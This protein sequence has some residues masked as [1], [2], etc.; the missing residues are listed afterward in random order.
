[1]TVTAGRLSPAPTAKAAASKLGG[2]ERAARLVG[3]AVAL[4][5][6]AEQ[7]G[8]EVAVAVFVVEGGDGVVA[9]RKTGEHQVAGLGGRAHARFHDSGRVG[10][11]HAVGAAMDGDADV[12]VGRA[13]ALDTHDQIGGGGEGGGRQRE[14]GG[15]ERCELVCGG[16]FHRSVLRQRFAAAGAPRRRC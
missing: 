7:V 10:E 16:C 14:G 13:H 6:H 15:A 12:A 2:P 3:E 11:V 4:G 8:V 9:G 5:R 1:M